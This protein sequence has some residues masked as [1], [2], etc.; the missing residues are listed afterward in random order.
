M[1]GPCTPR[2]AGIGKY[3]LYTGH[4][5]VIGKTENSLKCPPF[6]VNNGEY[7]SRRRTLNNI[8]VGMQGNT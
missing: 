8:L 1:N 3:S 6:I 2:S 5:Y 4:F 7:I